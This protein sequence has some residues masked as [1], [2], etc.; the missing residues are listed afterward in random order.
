MGEA[1]GRL[2]HLTA[3]LR[4]SFGVTA[5]VLDRGNPGLERRAQLAK[6]VAFRDRV[7]EDSIPDHR[8]IGRDRDRKRIADAARLQ[9]GCTTR[10][11]RASGG[12]T[13]SGR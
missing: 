12:S 1:G 6:G 8:A 4:P 10:S 13:P 9:R 3:R 11:T 5:G 7:L 2:Q